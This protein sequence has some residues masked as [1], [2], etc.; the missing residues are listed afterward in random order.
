MDISSPGH[1]GTCMFQP[2]GR[3]STWTFHLCGR[4]G[5]RTFWHGD[6]LAQRFFGTMDVSARRH[7]GTWTFRHSSTGAE[8]SILLWKVPKY[9]GAEMFRCRNIPCQKVHGAANSLCQNV[10]MPKSPCVETSREMKCPSAG[11]SAGSRL[12]TV[13]LSMIFSI[14]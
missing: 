7:F 12:S 3:T 6:F 4:F 5:T 13:S 14:V 10:P 1:F 8:M 11:T 2:C 9:P